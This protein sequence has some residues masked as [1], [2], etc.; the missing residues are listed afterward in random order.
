MPCRGDKDERLD[1]P[2]HEQWSRGSFGTRVRELNARELEMQLRR[3]GGLP[4]MGRVEAAAGAEGLRQ[5]VVS[6]AGSF[7][8]GAKKRQ[9]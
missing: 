6:C 4:G 9:E 1:A 2:A 8:E 7:N 5:L 3:G